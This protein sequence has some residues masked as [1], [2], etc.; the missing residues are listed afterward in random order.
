[1]K[2]LSTFSAIIPQSTSFQFNVHFQ[3]VFT[4]QDFD[5]TPE[6]VFLDQV[7]NVDSQVEFIE[8]TPL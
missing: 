8:F 3:L 6:L 1:L 2:K 4:N 7:D 5:N